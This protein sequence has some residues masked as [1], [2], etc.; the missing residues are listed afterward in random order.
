M[1]KLYLIL[2]VIGFLIPNYLVVLESL[3][4]GN[5]LLYTDLPATFAAMFTNRISSIF[6]IDLLLVV[7][8]FFIWS[9]YS[10]KIR[11]FSSL[12]GVWILTMLFGLAM[13]FPLLLYLREEK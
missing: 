6:A 3:E 10:A 13:G 12:Y 2:T 5:Y 9:F 1:K 7:L 4:T 11:N 8:M